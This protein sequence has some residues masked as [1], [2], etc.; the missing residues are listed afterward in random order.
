VQALL[1]EFYLQPD[2][3]SGAAQPGQT[4]APAH[5]PTGRSGGGLSDLQPMMLMPIMLLLLYFLMIRPEQKRRRETD[6]M[7]KAL[8]RGD[9][10]RTTGGIRGE[11][12][13]LN[14]IDATLLIAE[15]VKINVLRSAIAGKA[16]A[17][18][19]KEKP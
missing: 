14:E 3:T 16:A 9:I 4:G 15:K 5:E 18:E 19:A 7:V 13:E 17:T 11:I 12:V 6:E 10:V 8:K 2:A 1:T